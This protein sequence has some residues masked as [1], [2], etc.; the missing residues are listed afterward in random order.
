MK[1]VNTGLNLTNTVGA[2]MAAGAFITN[3]RTTRVMIR[4]YNQSRVYA[5]NG[6]R[7]ESSVKSG[8]VLLRII[9]KE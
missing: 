8:L 3:K 9:D 7:D 1:T 5:Y 2:R 6:P 4:G